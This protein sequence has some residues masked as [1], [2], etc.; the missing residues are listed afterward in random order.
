MASNNA[1]NVSTGKPKVGGAVFVA[2]LGSTLPTNAKSA[3]NA[4]FDNT[5]YCSESGMANEITTNS[6][7]INAWGGEEVD[8]SQTSHAETYKFT[9]IETNVVTLE[10]VY[11]AENVDVEGTTG[12]I[13]VKHNALEK[14]A[15]SWV[16]EILMKGN[17]I[18]RIVVP[19]G[20]INSL[21]AIT[22]ADNSA[23]NYGVTLSA[24]PDENG[25]KSIEYIDT[26][27]EG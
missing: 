1:S 16:F 4:A 22:Y 23:I 10:Q 5:G 20:K 7:S 8:N 11:G 3:L 26:L 17:R 6:Q 24:L 14:T 2:P 27:V 13:T 25:D 21:D 19:N 15:C 18:K 12:A 9:M